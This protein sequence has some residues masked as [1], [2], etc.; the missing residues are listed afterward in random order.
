MRLFLIFR[1]DS[2]QRKRFN[3]TY[4]KV[5]IVEA[6][7]VNKMLTEISDDEVRFN[8]GLAEP[9]YGVC[10]SGVA[11]VGQIT[12]MQGEGVI[13]VGS[14]QSF[15]TCETGIV[16]HDIVE[17]ADFLNQIADEQQVDLLGLISKAVN[18][19]KIHHDHF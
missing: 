9:V 16:E 5:Y 10:E 3:Q 15:L 17:S 18:E 1:K 13:D 2:Y 12:V 11:F 14:Y 7:N 19:T 4:L 6:L 8:I